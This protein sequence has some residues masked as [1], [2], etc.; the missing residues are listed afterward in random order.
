MKI[1]VESKICIIVGATKECESVEKS[2]K[3]EYNNQKGGFFMSFCTN[4][5]KP[6]DENAK[7]CQE[8][9]MSAEEK[10]SLVAEVQEEG[11]NCSACGGVVP[12]YAAVCPYCGNEVK[13]KGTV[14]GFVVFLEQVN[15][16]ENAVR[17]EKETRFLGRVFAVFKKLL[18]IV[19]N[20]FFVCFPLVIRFIANLINT[21]KTPSLTPAEERLARFIENY[22]FPNN[23][24]VILE[25]LVFAKG[26]IDF[27]SKQQVS[28]KNTYWMRLWFSKA[29][30]LKD[31][32]DALFPKDVVAEVS[33]QEILADQ[34]RI[35]RLAKLK[36]A[37][38]IVLIFGVVIFFYSI[39]TAANEFAWKTHGAYAT[40]PT[41]QDANGFLIEDTDQVLMFTLT[42]VSWK[43]FETYRK[44]CEEQ[45]YNKNPVM[46]TDSYWAENDQGY[47]LV[48]SYSIEEQ[49]LHVAVK[50]EQ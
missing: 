28:R 8:C 14:K 31:K 36:I 45:G 20:I 38:G 32:A 34:K 4:C 26:K 48:L 7:F 17:Q 30:Q 9:G 46:G 22:T 43:E 41:M 25:A 49:H 16:L 13:A 3:K 44:Q 39:G 15:N 12:A 35:E 50:T 47:E 5:G 10:V 2:W 6:M 23:R 33:F 27:L 18:W 19:F 37:G 42:D 11:R 1:P 21:G 40:L 24:E 29:Q